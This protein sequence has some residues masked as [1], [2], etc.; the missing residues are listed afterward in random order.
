MLC[1]KEQLGSTA[2]HEFERCCCRAKNEDFRFDQGMQKVFLMNWEVV[3]F[4]L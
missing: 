3:G 2:D 4:A 1:L